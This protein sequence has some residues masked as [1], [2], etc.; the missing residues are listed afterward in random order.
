MRIPIDS[1]SGITITKLI[2]YQTPIIEKKGSYA[3]TEYKTVWHDANRAIN[4]KN[5][6]EESLKY[7]QKRLGKTLQEI[8]RTN[9]DSLIAINEAKYYSEYPMDYKFGEVWFTFNS[10]GEKI[11]LVLNTI[12]KK[13]YANIK[14]KNPSKQNFE[15]IDSL[16]VY[17]SP[18]AY[19]YEDGIL[20]FGDQMNI[21]E[22]LNNGDSNVNYSLKGFKDVLFRAQEYV[23]SIIKSDTRVFETVEN[24]ATGIV[25]KSTSD[26]P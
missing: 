23:R 26:K 9:N 11:V 2:Y 15:S 8:K 25:V 4:D 22:R 18:K 10:T 3:S 1:I 17:G 16:G 7:Y 13:E 6:P 12:K 14:F 20:K 19:I 5:T 21:L 24:T